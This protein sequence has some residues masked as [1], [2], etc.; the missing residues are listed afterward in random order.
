MGIMRI[1]AL[2][3][4]TLWVPSVAYAFEPPPKKTFSERLDLADHVIVGTAKKV[5]VVEGI[6]D[7]KGHTD[8]KEVTPEPDNIDGLGQYVEVEIEINEVLYPSKWEVPK[9]VR[10]MFGGGIFS[11]ASVR[12]DTVGKRQIYLI[13]REYVGE[14]NDAEN[15]FFPSWGWHL[16]ESLEAKPQ[17]VE[18]LKKRMEKEQK[19]EEDK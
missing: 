6:P 8:L 17:I 12:E 14:L 13:S 7:G 19:P 15:V 18:M 4:L 16:A 11:V 1:L 3:L 5:R 2:F 10:Y 9:T